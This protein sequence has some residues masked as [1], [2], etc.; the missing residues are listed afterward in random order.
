MHRRRARMRLTLL[1]VVLFRALQ[2]SMFW[3]RPDCAHSTAPVSCSSDAIRLT[4]NVA[5]IAN[6]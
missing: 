4:P 6:P 1:A 3:T 2:Q 5:R